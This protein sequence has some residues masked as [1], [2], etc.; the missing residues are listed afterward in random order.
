[1]VD[2]EFWKKGLYCQQQAHEYANNCWRFKNDELL[3]ALWWMYQV[4]NC[5]GYGAGKC[6]KRSFPPDL[7]KAIKFSPR[8]KQ[9]T[10]PIIHQAQEILIS[11][12]GDENC[13]FLLFSRCYFMFVCRP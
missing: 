1:M 12:I 11:F 9:L 4:W 10:Y 8:I 3:S 2:C 7:D 6:S 13:H 5:Q